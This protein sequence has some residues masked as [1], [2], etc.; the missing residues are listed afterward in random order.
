M[1]ALNGDSTI[2]TGVH[3]NDAAIVKTVA[4]TVAFTECRV[5]CAVI[6]AKEKIGAPQTRRP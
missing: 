1:I 2:A 3:N 6:A 4:A 5:G